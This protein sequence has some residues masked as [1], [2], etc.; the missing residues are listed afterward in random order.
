MG[1]GSEEGLVRAQI[2]A[3]QVGVGGRSERGELVEGGHAVGPRRVRQAK[4]LL[5]LTHGRDAGA[6][7]LL[8]GPRQVLDRAQLTAGHREDVDGPEERGRQEAVG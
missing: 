7:D 2:D 5:G 8:G 3:G 4:Q 6:G 1:Q